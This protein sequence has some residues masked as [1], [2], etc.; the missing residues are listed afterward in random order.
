MNLSSL[1]KLPVLF[2]CENNCWAGAQSI[3]EHCAVGDI[4][5]RA[6][7]YGMPGELVDGNDV[8]QVYAL[9][10]KM[11]KYC[12]NVQGP[13]FIE[14]KTYRMRGHGEH[15]RQHYVDKKELEEWSRSCPVNRLR[16]TLLAEGLLSEA[17]L[18]TIDTKTE[19]R[20]DEAAKFGTESPYPL[21]EEALEDVWV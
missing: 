9:A 11:V 20:I 10:K 3:R 2:V 16:N 7:G 8:T 18:Q 14:A 15:D 21:P 6:A 19:A 12:R 1:W 4:A 17:E 13:A 5:A